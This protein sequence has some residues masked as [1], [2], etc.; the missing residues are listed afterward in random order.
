ML[1]L[2]VI[3]LNAQLPD[4]IKFKKENNGFFFFQKG[5]TTDTISLNRGDL[6][7]LHVGDSL[8]K[9]ISILVENASMWP[10]QGD[11][12]IQLRYVPGIRYEHVY[13]KEQAHATGYTFKSLVNGSA[14]VEKN[15]ILIQVFD[16]RKEDIIL[17]NRYVF[18]RTD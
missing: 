13:I 18:L 2:A 4:K 10:V 11:T 17:E 3:S 6:F 9:T 5:N 1:I 16:K 15:K 12:T 8:K 7:Y 14:V